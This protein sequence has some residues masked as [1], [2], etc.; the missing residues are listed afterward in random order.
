MILQ[1]GLDPDGNFVNGRVI[2]VAL[3]PNGVPY[4]DD[5]FQSVILVRKLTRQDFPQTPLVIDDM[6][7]ILRDSFTQ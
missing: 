7:Y 5:Y 3:D 2:P 1:V 4:L 6:D